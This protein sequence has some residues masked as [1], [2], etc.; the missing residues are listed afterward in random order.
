MNTLIEAL[1][2]ILGVPNFYI[3]GVFDYGALIEYSI[4]ALLLLI[5]VSSA[6]KFLRLLVK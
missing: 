2:T 5:V 4:C 1:R 3:D 6:F